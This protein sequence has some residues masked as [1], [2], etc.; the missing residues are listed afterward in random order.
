[1]RDARA[2]APTAELCADVASKKY[3]T[4]NPPPGCIDHAFVLFQ[5]G[6]FLSP[7]I[8]GPPMLFFFVVRDAARAW[9][10]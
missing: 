1:M 4:V 10:T 6:A 7:L 8:I 9:L 3:K 2:V 5:F